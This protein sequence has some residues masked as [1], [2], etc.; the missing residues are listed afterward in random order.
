[1]EVLEM[2]GTVAETSISK[3]DTSGH[4]LQLNLNN[5]KD[6]GSKTD[7]SEFNQ[8]DLQSLKK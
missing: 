5:N 3:T 1:M 8:M 2:C 4:E 7:W 6:K